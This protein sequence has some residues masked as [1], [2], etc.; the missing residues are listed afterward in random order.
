MKRAV[1]LFLP[2]AMALLGCGSARRSE[3]IVGPIT[4]SGKAAE[5]EIAFMRQCNS[6]H[7][8]GEAG[9]GPAINNKPLPAPAIK[10]QIRTGALGGTMP[11]FSPQ[12][13]PD[14]QVDTIIAYLEAIRHPPA[15]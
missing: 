13:L 15:R 9:V 7:P 6:C 12:E 3:P 2:M 10:L 14:D 11:P 8:H 5:G 1:P 4:L